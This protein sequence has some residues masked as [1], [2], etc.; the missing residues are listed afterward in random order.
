MVKLSHNIWVGATEEPAIHTQTTATSP[1]TIEDPLG[2]A[3]E[4]IA[5]VTQPQL[6]PHLG[7]LK[8][9]GLDFGWG[10][11]AFLE[12]SVEH[13]HVLL[14]TPWWATLAIATLA[15]RGALFQ[16]Y[17]GAADN[18]ARIAT[19][20]LHLKDVQNRIDKAKQ[21]R[22][23]NAMVQAT[24]ELKNAYAA[25]GIKM[26]K[27]FLP[28]LQLPLGIGMF[29]LAR[30]L[31]TLPVP[32]LEDGGF[33][34]FRDLTVSDPTFLLPITTGVASFYLFKLGGEVAG[35]NTLPPAMMAGMKWGM[36]VLSVTF[37]SFWPAAM[38]FVFA[39]TSI[40][41]L[42][43]SIA[44]RQPWFRR[45]LGIH[46]MPSPTGAGPQTGTKGMVI[47]TT[48]R[49]QPQMPDAPAQGLVDS[50]RSKLRNFV[51][52]NQESPSVGRSKGQM[53]E[54]QRYEEKRRR[55]IKQEKYEAEQERH[56]RRYERR[57]RDNR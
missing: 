45:F 4:I 43:Q 11:T 7:F 35:T 56:R 8:E 30:N 13:V 53:A 33:L 12:W 32:G 29:R 36:P 44:F 27:N 49:V 55:E 23:L 31:A 2:N 57:T 38:Q 16:I 39:W 1:S 26:W 46:P 3:S 24:Q 40:L 19:V 21:A 25:A 37:M 42:F 5:S 41:A 51:E 48:A 17:V 20:Q 6:E 10:P 14:G 50:A 9:L 28:F 34:W 22:D 54:A 18:A 15:I 52:M 47:E